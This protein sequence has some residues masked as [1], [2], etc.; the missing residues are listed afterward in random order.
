VE[1]FLRIFS[2]D[3]ATPDPGVLLAALAALGLNLQGN[4]EGDAEGWFLAELTLPSG[5]VL[6][7]ERYLAH[8]EGIRN[9]LNAWAAVLEGREQLPQ[10]AVLMER[11]IQSWQLFVLPAHVGRAASPEVALLICRT[12]ATLTNGFYQLD[13]EGFFDASGTLLEPE[14]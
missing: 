10:A 11:V 6:P 3:E 7:L 2:R 13:G 4:F 9:E 8:E 5:E 1:T 12:L 14:E